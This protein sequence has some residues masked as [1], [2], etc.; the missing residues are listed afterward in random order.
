MIIWLLGAI[1]VLQL[2]SIIQGRFIVAAIDD[3]TTAVTGL[4]SASA[5]II[6]KLNQLKSTGVDPTQVE[7]LVARV[8]TATNNLNSAAQ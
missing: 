5:A 2:I 6:T 3:L 1:A 4:E 7:A 8:N